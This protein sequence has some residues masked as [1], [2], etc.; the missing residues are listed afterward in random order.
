MIERD[1]ESYEKNNLEEK[2]REHTSD[3]IPP[4]LQKGN[5]DLA[6]ALADSFAASL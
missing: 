4:P 5:H 3:Q 2:G 1:H 6:V